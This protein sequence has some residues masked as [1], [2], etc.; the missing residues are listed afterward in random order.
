MIRIKEFIR[1]CEESRIGFGLWL[2]TALFIILIRDS[3]ESLVSVRSFSSVNM[4]HFLHV[5]IFFLT[6]LL[7]IIILLRL[8]TKEDILKVSK[9]CLVF[10]AIII[11]PAVTDLIVSFLSKADISYGYI[12]G[13]VKDSVINFFNPF[14]KIPDVPYSLRAE[15]LIICAFVFLYIFIKTRRLL[16]SLLGGFLVFCLCALY[17]AL[18][19]LLIGGFVKVTSF[20]FRAFHPYFFGKVISG[21]VDEGVVVIIELV[22][23]FFSAGLWFWL[24]DSGKFKAVLM[25]FRPSRYLVCFILAGTG[26]SLYLCGAGAIDVFIAVRILGLFLALFFAVRFSALINDIFDVE[27]DKLTNRSRPLVSGLILE[28]EYFKVGLV[29]LAFSLL[30]ASWVSESCFVITLIFIGVYFLYSAPPF[31]LKRFFI[32]SS[33]VTGIQALLILLMGQLSLAQPGTTILLFPPLLSLVFLVFFLSS[34]IKDLKDVQADMSGGIYSLPVVFGEKKARRII[35]FLVFLSY[36]LAPVFLSG[37]IY[38]NFIA[39]ISILF[40]FINYFYI[41]RQNSREQAVFLLFFLY[42]L[43]LVLILMVNGA[44]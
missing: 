16:R 28:S 18:P 21:V 40:G 17:G 6:A 35:A 14:Y 3:I 2:A 12:D 34:N 42:V 43:L 20:L 15:I 44:I 5:P 4:F 11:F 32:F 22:F 8:F 27:G 26:I 13:N 31:R 29:Y 24:Y 37:F 36:I 41:R 1:N 10:F 39:V 30:F 23:A 7:S 38:S 9:I 19:G 25:D 33:L